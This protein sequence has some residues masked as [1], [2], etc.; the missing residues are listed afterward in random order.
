[1]VKNQKQKSLRKNLLFWSSS[2]L[3]VIIIL[4][5]NIRQF[6]PMNSKE[7]SSTHDKKKLPSDNVKSDTDPDEF[8]DEEGDE[9][10]DEVEEVEET[11]L[12]QIKTNEGFKQILNE[13]LAAK[14]Y[15]LVKFG[16]EWCPP[17]KRI[18]PQLAKLA[19]DNLDTYVFEVDKDKSPGLFSENKISTMPTIILFRAIKDDN[20]DGKDSKYIEP[21]AEEVRR[22]VG[23]EKINEVI[24]YVKNQNWKDDKQVSMDPIKSSTS[25]PKEVSKTTDEEKKKML[26]DQNVVDIK[27]K[28]DDNNL[29]NK[30][31]VNKNTPSDTGNNI[32]AVKRGLVKNPPTPIKPS[33]S[34]AT[35]NGGYR[36]RFDT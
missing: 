24:E 2:G 20:K 13:A 16:A 32:P 4:A 35:S 10:E 12:V 9:E 7:N 17:C 27:I 26:V 34:S 1:M 18:V 3:L 5:L 22:W 6:I 33:T 31:V 8:G 30:N 25:T 36:T 29:P 11:E 15:I 21:R 28:A 14:K 23:S 19:K